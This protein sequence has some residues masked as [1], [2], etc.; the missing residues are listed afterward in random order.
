MI[1]SRAVTVSW[2][3]WLFA[4][5]RTGYR[6][7]QYWP[8]TPTHPLSHWT[9]ETSDNYPVLTSSRVSSIRPLFG[10]LSDKSRHSYEHLPLSSNALWWHQTWWQMEP[11]ILIGP[12]PRNDVSWGGYETGASWSLLHYRQ[13]RVLGKDSR[14]HMP[15]VASI[16]GGV[17]GRGV[18]ST[19]APALC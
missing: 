15:P 19:D 9:Q 6:T 16:S 7:G 10:D 14:W 13:W 2:E 5:S 11:F 17:Q 18:T 1:V 4:I 12:H 3:S 8:P